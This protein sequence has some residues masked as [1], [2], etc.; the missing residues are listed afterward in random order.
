MNDRPSDSPAPGPESAEIQAMS[1]RVMQ[2]ELLTMH[3]QHDLDQMNQ[4][5]IDQQKELGR[6][7]QILATIDDRVQRLEP[8][9]KI[10]P[11]SERPPHY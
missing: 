3:L 6:L 8:T 4:A 5:L 11:I 9:D 7:R 2:L 1:Q 10:D